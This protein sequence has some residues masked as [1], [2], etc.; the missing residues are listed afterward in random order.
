M[1]NGIMPLQKND[2][3]GL[4][5]LFRLARQGKEIIPGQMHMLIPTADLERIAVILDYAAEAA[6]DDY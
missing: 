5:M 1:D 6:D 4:A 2:L 3:I